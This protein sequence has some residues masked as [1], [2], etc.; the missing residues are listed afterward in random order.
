M[1]ESTNFEMYEMYINTLRTILVDYCE[2]YHIDLKN[3]R[4]Y[5]ILG[6]GHGEYPDGVYSQE[7]QTHIKL[8]RILGEDLDQIQEFLSIRHIREG[9]AE[10]DSLNRRYQRTLRN[11]HIEWCLINIIPYSRQD[12]QVTEATMTIRSIQKMIDE[13]TQRMEEQRRRLEQEHTKDQMIRTACEQATKADTMRRTFMRRINHDLRDTINTVN[14]ALELAQNFIE[15]PEKVLTFLDMAGHAS[16]HLMELLN[17]TQELQYMETDTRSIG[18]RPFYL[19][20]VLDESMEMVSQQARYRQHHVELDISRL[21]HDY[22]EGEQRKLKQVIVNILGNAIKYT[23]NGGQ[24]SVSITETSG[25]TRD[26]SLYDIEVTDNGI[27]MNEEFLDQIFEPF[28]RAEDTYVEDQMGTGL[29]MT[30]AKS[31]VKMMNGTIKIT[32][33]PG[34]GTHVHLILLFPWAELS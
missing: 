11:G 2:V 5:E 19:S 32:S 20:Q 1:S 22:V 21:W 27:G 14:G 9:L 10:T 30:I 18:T 25:N 26:S 16:N 34:E 31:M 7:I 12:G 3:D 8:N 29:G 23:P 24:I 13:E 33:K 6:N 28:S 15:N 4:Y 17:E